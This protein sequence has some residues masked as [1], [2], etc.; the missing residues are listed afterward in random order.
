V[1]ES[2]AAFI[3]PYVDDMLLI[4]NYIGLLEIIKGYLNKSLS[5]KDLGEGMYILGINI[6]R[7]R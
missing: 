1:S 4:E 3:I 6:N 5:M 2:F 7:D